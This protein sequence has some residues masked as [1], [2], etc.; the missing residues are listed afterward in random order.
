MFCFSLFSR[1]SVWKMVNW[2]R[3]NYKIRNRWSNHQLCIRIWNKKEKGKCFIYFLFFLL[4]GCQWF[5]CKGCVHGV[6][7]WEGNEWV[8]VLYRI[9]VCVRA[10]ICFFLT[11]AYFELSSLW[12]LPYFLQ[13]YHPPL[14]LYRVEVTPQ[15]WLNMIRTWWILNLFIRA[16]PHGICWIRDFRF[17]WMLSCKR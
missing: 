5:K 14:P 11:R 3:E 8:G 4:P 7:V 6:V 1:F 2:M 17:F 13:F 16:V 9:S 15:S 12:E 10:F